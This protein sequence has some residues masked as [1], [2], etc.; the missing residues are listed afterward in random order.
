MLTLRCR[1]KGLGLLGLI[2]NGNRLIVVI[3]VVAEHELHRGIADEVVVHLVGLPG[4]DKRFVDGLVMHHHVVVLF[5][6]QILRKEVIE[7]TGVLDGSRASFALRHPQDDGDVL[8][9][10]AAHMVLALCE[11]R[12]VD[13]YTGILD[14]GMRKNKINKLEIILKPLFRVFSRFPHSWDVIGKL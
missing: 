5:A 10:L 13:F 6:R 14:P 12:F 9:Q 11:K 1:R 3:L 8:G 7:E 2:G 4:D